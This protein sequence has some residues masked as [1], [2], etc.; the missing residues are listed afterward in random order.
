MRIAV[1][2][3]SFNPIHV[4]HLILASNVASE[5]GYDKVIF[6]PTGNPPHKQMENGGQK[7]P[8]AKDRFN[9]VRLAVK[10]DRRFA[11]DDCEIKR[12]GKSYTF[13]TITYL[14]EKYGAS[15]EGKI[16]L[17]MGDDLLPGF[18]LW[19]RA[20]ELSRKC[21][22]IL[23]LRKSQS[24]NKGFENHATGEY[25]NIENSENFDYTKDSLFENAIRLQNPVV[26]VSSTQI[27]SLA[28][29]GQSL[30]YLVPQKVFKY[31]RK[32]K[33]YGYE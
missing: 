17:I 30:E 8:S 21:D 22:L 4:G 5:L 13:D 28:S 1:L 16:G 23:A 26:T 14:E 3:G 7:A 18:H 11:V 12:E 27:R 32:R 19:H 31:I 29:R 25:A 33:I 20:E 2:G 6:V 24:E 15:L 9:M 10:G